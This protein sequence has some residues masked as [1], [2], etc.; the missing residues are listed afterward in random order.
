[1]SV[2]AV[3][4]GLIYR[5]AVAISPCEKGGAFAKENLG[6]LRPRLVTV[7]RLFALT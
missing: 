4:R 3:L 1:M 6:N 2:S 5:T 7:M